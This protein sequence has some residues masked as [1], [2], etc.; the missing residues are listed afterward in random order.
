MTLMHGFIQEG[1]FYDDVNFPRGF[2]K[3]GDFN[4]SESE[5]LTDIGRRLSA[6]ESGRSTPQNETEEA[7]VEMCQFQ[8]Q[9]QTRVEMLW[10]KYKKLTTYRPF[11]SLNGSAKVH[12]VE[13]AMEEEEEEEIVV[14]EE[15]DGTLIIDDE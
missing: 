2:R 6:L 5:M 3:S 10:Q 15:L 13:L 7:F 1:L 9:A 8:T 11:H 14:E 4:I 12:R